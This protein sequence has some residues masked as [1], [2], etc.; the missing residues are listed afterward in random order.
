[1]V[2]RRLDRGWKTV[3]EMAHSRVLVIGLRRPQFLPP[4]V[5]A[6]PRVS[7]TK[8]N[9]AG[10]AMVFGNRPQKSQSITKAGSFLYTPDKHC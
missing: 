9:E 4:M 7:D 6:S 5:V 3:S 8:E 2:I 1:M 10:A